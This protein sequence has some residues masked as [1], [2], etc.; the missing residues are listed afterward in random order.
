MRHLAD[1]HRGA[2]RLDLA[3]FSYDEALALY[4]DD[5]RTAPLDFANALRGVALLRDE[6]GDLEAGKRLWE[7]AR[8][9][10]LSVGVQE[11]FEECNTRL[12]A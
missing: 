9:L 6:S 7:E 3:G 10:Y 4:R 5:P 11:G 1:L 2:G 8:A 12:S